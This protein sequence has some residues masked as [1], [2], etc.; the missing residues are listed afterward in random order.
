MQVCW[1]LV[2]RVTGADGEPTDIATGEVCKICGITLEVWPLETMEQKLHRYL[3]DQGFASEVMSVRQGVAQ[4]E[5]HL[6]ASTKQQTVQATQ[7]FGQRVSIKAAFVTDEVFNVHFSMPV[8]SVAQH[9]DTMKVANLL[10]PFNIHL[11][12]V[13]FHI[14]SLPTTI[15]HYVVELFC[16]MQRSLD[17]Q[18]LA[19]EGCLRPGHAADRHA[20]A[21]KALGNERNASAAGLAAPFGLPQY[22]DVRRIVENIQQQR[23]LEAE[24][25]AVSMHERL[26]RGEEGIIRT[27]LSVYDCF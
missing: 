2:H 20:Y 14:W 24:A 23:A 1:F 10:G 9:C 26:V 11:S 16:E 19:P 4:G 15:P 3:T 8:D 7:L 25:A 6:R 21:V 18:L 27:M 13:L 5:L 17:D 12:G 22:D